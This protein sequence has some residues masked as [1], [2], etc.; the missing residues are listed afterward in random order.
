MKRANYD[1][2]IVS[3]TAPEY[4]RHEKGEKWFLIAGV[5]MLAFVIYGLFTNAWTFS[6]AL[7]VVSAVYY[8]LHFEH[9]NNVEVII[10][11]MGIKVGKRVY[12]YNKIQAF[13]IIYH[14]P[15]V[16]TLNIRTGSKLLPD[17]SIQLNGQDPAPIR[18]YLAGQI[19]E[20]EGKEEN[21]TDIL[22]RLFKI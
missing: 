18:E 2:A 19:P 13:W 20:W 4:I 1:E 3:W 8:L 17:I 14:P 7:V 11:D 22:V 9:P 5:F 21:F 10:S 16:E 6:L 15:H 12:P